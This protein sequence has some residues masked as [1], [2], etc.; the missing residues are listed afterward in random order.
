MK[1]IDVRFKGNVMLFALGED[2]CQDYWGDDWGDSVED[3]AHH[4]Y[5]YNKYVKCYAEVIVPYKYTVLPYENYY[6]FMSMEKL[7]NSEAPICVISEEHTAF[8]DAVMK[9][10]KVL[11]YYLND[12]MEPGTYILKDL[13][14]GLEKMEID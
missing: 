13:S 14:I 9:N 1:I 6:T 7:K 11:K 8:L 12:S 10:E 4:D 3:V 5:V 2:N